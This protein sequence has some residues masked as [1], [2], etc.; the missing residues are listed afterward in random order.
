MEVVVKTY[1]SPKDA[2]QDAQRMAAQGWTPQGMA[3]GGT[4]FAPIKGAAQ[5]AAW[6]F[7]IPG[8]GLIGGKKWRKNE[9]IVITWVR[10][11]LPVTAAPRPPEASETAAV[12]YD[13]RNWSPEDIEN[14]LARVKY[15]R[16]PHDWDESAQVLTVPGK[17]EEAMSKFVLGEG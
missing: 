7:F 15:W 10:D 13:L 16:I 12:E 2:E 6:N 11:G 4:R 9:P 5:F 3:G 1:K 17:Y 8:A 14:A